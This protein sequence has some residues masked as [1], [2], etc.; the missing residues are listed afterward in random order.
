[1]AAILARVAQVID[2]DR[3]PECVPAEERYFDE[4]GGIADMLDMFAEDVSDTCKIG[5]LANRGEGLAYLALRTADLHVM[6]AVYA[7]NLRHQ[8]DA[9]L[10]REEHD[11]A[12]ARKPVEPRKCECCYTAK[13]RG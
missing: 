5:S 4:R 13:E 1:M 8:A 3:L 12:V 2:I 9:E 10:A 7:Y 6:R 11:A